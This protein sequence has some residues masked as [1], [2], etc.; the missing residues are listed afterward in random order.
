[1]NPPATLES[2]VSAIQKVAGIRRSPLT[3]PRS[4]ILGIS[5]PIDAV[6]RTLHISQPISP[7]RVRKLFRSTSIEPRKLQ[8]LGYTWRFTLEDAFRDWKQDFSR[9]FSA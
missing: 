7:V 9:D 3:I 1:M 2:F 4:L 8:E 5:Y 6:A